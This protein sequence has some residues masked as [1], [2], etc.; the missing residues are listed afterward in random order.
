MLLIILISVYSFGREAQRSGVA[1]LRKA[2]SIR[3]PMSLKARCAFDLLE[4]YGTWVVIAMEVQRLISLTANARKTQ[5]LSEY[6][7][8]VQR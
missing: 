4:R 5:G 2:P 8:M 3:S 1:S 7:T 6:F